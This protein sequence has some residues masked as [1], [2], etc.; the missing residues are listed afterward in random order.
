ME[1]EELLDVEPL[2]LDEVDPD[3]ELELVV[4]PEDDELDDEPPL[5]DDVQLFEKFAASVV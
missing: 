5:L 1:P 3:D 2:L 4:E